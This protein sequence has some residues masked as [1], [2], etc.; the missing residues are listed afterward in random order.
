MPLRQQEAAAALSAPA[1]H[2]V[3]GIAVDDFR[4]DETRIVGRQKH[5]EPGDIVGHPMQVQHLRALY[6]RIGFDRQAAL[7]RGRFHDKS[8]ERRLGTECVSACRSRWLTYI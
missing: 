6:T 5:T 7:G 4:G 3:A 8:E 2:A 1:T